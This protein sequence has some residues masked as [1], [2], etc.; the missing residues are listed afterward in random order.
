M[1][2]SLADLQFP[3]G[4]GPWYTYKAEPKAA[5][6][7]AWTKYDVLDFDGGKVHGHAVA[8][9]IPLIDGYA[10]ALEKYK[11]GKKLYQVAMPGSLIPMEAGEEIQPGEL[12]KA[13]IATTTPAGRDTLA[14]PAVVA[15]IAAGRVL[16]RMRCH[17]RNKSLLRDAAD[18][19]IILVQTG[20][21]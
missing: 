19:N 15:D 16:G 5:V 6:T 4:Y 1:P 9:N 18:A 7:L 13:E 3:V 14:H 8:T 12:V 11:V 2:A 20:V 17:Y 21:L 10:I